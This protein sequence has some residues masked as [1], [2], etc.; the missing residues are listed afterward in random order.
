[1]E[2]MSRKANSCRS[3]TAQCKRERLAPIELGEVSATELR[4]ELGISRSL[5]QRRKQLARHGTG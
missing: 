3:F 4:R 1:M 5:R 2:A